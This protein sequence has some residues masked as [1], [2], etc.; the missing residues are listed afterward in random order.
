MALVATDWE[1][2]INKAIRY[3]G[4]DHE[5]AGAGYVTVLDFE[6]RNSTNSLINTH[7]K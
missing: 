1:V 4:A 7:T 3:V 5:A 2:Q 6:L